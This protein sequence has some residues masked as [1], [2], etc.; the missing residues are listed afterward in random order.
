[1]KK[2]KT[3]TKKHCNFKWEGKLKQWKLELMETGTQKLIQLGP[4]TEIFMLSNIPL[5]FSKS[6]RPNLYLHF[7]RSGE[8]NS[9]IR[10]LNSHS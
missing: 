6:I 8:L 9:Q 7:V 3:K 1:M 4:L 5:S 10:N 2:K